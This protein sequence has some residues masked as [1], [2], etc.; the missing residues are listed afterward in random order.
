MVAF[1][2]GDGS[3]GLGRWSLERLA[4]VVR[5][6]GLE[7]AIIDIPVGLLESGDR[8]C[9]LE[10]RRLL[11]WPRGA[12]IFPAPLR[13]M[14]AATSY[15]QAQLI[16]RRLEGRGYSRQAFGILARVREVDRLL[17]GDLA[18]RLHEG[19]PELI[20][21]ALGDGVGPSSSKHTVEGRRQRWQLLRRH[22]SELDRL[23]PSRLRAHDALDAYACL[24]T[25]RRLARGKAAWVPARDQWAEGREQ[26]LR[27]W[28]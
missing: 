17:G 6:P 20:F 27:I 8:D 18:G 9:D 21:R 11:G 10:A 14:L 13:G 15:Q 7:A 3:T 16:R 12:S 23:D 25:A 19:H 22:F 2:R 1:E 26:P 28:Y 4:E 24:W 5:L